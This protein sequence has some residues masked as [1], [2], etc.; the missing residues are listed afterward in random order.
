[1]LTSY[2]CTEPLLSLNRA[3]RWPAAYLGWWAVAAACAPPASPCVARSGARR[4]PPYPPCTH[5]PPRPWAAPTG[6]P[7]GESYPAATTHP[8]SPHVLTRPHGLEQHRQVTQQES[9]P[10]AT[11]HP[12]SPHV[13]TRPYGLEEHRQVTEQQS[14][15]AA[16]THPTSPH[17]LTCPHRSRRQ[18]IFLNLYK[19]VIIFIRSWH[20]YRAD[21][22][23]RN[24]VAAGPP[25]TC[26]FTVRFWW[27]LWYL[28]FP[29]A[30]NC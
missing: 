13:L 21:L 17:V 22:S 3:R 20:H 14:Y 23:L 15:P 8:T 12:T 27:P 4:T 9:Y 5:T 2:V 1:M 16:T 29:L 18:Y 19:C 11:T 25:S 6:H 30:T 7:A 28:V 10:A 26:A 24:V